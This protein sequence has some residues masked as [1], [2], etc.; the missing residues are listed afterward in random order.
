MRTLSDIN[1]EVKRVERA[2]EIKMKAMEAAIVAD[3]SRV[4]DSFRA[5][6]RTLSSR[7]SA[8]Y[9]IRWLFDEKAESLS[10]L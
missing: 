8:L 2:V 7:L 1:K 5:D 10:V 9:A 4:V 3:Q 6:I